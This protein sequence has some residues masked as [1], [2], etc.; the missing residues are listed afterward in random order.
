M[1]GTEGAEFRES[2][3]NSWSSDIQIANDFAHHDESRPVSVIIGVNI[4][5]GSS[6]RNLSEE[7]EEEEVLTP[8]NARYKIVKA[9]IKNDKSG[10]Q[11]ITVRLEQLNDE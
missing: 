5:T 9:T 8:K 1:F 7:F 3:L 2:S 10:G 6:I 11:L 4:N